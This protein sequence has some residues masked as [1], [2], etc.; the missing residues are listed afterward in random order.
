MVW[1]MGSPLVVNVGNFTLNL[2]TCSFAKAQAEITHC[3]DQLVAAMI[4]GTRIP[5]PR[6]IS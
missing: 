3:V 1:R 2:S 6:L 4:T 5:L